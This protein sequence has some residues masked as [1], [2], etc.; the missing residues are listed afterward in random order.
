MTIDSRCFDFSIGL[1]LNRGLEPAIKPARGEARRVLITMAKYMLRKWFLFNV[2]QP[3]VQ[4]MFYEKETNRQGNLSAQLSQEKFRR[5]AVT[6]RTTPVY[7]IPSQ[8]KPTEQ[9]STKCASKSLQ[10]FKAYRVCYCSK[11]ERSFE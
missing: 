4:V 11:L 3:N 8:L 6:T 5:R 1:A 2:I 9:N 10:R 7:T